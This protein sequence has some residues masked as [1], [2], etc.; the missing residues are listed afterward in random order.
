MTRTNCQ[1]TRE[2]ETPQGYS[3]WSLRVLLQDYARVSHGVMSK[4]VVSSGNI[5]VCQRV[6]ITTCSWA[7]GEQQGIMLGGHRKAQETEQYRAASTG[8]RGTWSS[9]QCSA[10]N[11]E[12]LSTSTLQYTWRSLHATHKEFNSVYK[13]YCNTTWRIKHLYL[14]SLPITYFHLSFLSTKLSNLWFT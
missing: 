2:V 3:T 11:W 1:S 10:G 14:S 4:S 12:K 8:Y 9:E 13:I 6:T 7:T 5:S